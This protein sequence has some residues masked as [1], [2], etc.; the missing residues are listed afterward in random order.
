VTVT[1]N[2]TKTPTPTVTPGVPDLVI[3]NI[4]GAGAVSLAGGALQQYT[5]TITNTGNGATGTFRCSYTGQDGVETELGI[6]SGL[7]AGESIALVANVTFT[8]TGST[9]ILAKADVDNQ[10]SEI[11]EVNNSAALPVNVGA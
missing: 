10:I 2:I 1:P 8:T 3:S 5:V 11:S 4:A 6:V 9:F 7:N